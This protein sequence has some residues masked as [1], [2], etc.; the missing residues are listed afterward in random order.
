MWAKNKL[1][2]IKMIPINTHCKVVELEPL[3][4]EDLIIG[5]GETCTV[6]KILRVEPD[7]RDNLYAVTFFRDVRRKPLN[8][9]FDGF[10]EDFYPI[11]GW[12]LEPI[13]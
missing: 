12:Q 3:D 11:Y 2:G 8:V 5:I 13:V 6:R 7:E 4:E 9:Q 10:Y 1:G